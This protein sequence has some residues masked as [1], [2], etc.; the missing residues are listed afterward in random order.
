M[1]K[2]YILLFIGL[3][4]LIKA[5]GQIITSSLQTEL[6]NAGPSD[7]ISIIIQMNDQIDCKDLQDSLLNNLPRKEIRQF[8]VNELKSFADTSQQAIM[9]T[10]TS[11]EALG[12]AENVRQ[13]WIVN[14]ITCKAK[15]AAINQLAQRQDISMLHIDEVFEIGEIV[16]DNVMTPP[17]TAYHIKTMNVPAVWNLGYKG[18]GVVVAVLDT[19]VDIRH[20][21]LENNMWEGDGWNIIAWNDSV[22]DTEGHGTLVAGIIAGDGTAG[23]IT[24]VAPKAKIMAIKVGYDGM[25]GTTFHSFF[26]A[27]IAW[28]LD[29]G[30]DIFNLSWQNRRTI[31]PET[32]RLWRQ[33]MD[34]VL[35]SS[36]VAV[37]AAGNIDPDNP[38]GIPPDRIGVPGRIPPPWKHPHQN[39]WGSEGI[40]SAVVCV[41]AIDSIGNWWQQSEF[42]PVTWSNVPPYN[43][44]PYDAQSEGLRRPDVV[45]PG[46]AITSLKANTIEYAN[47]DGT[48][49]SAPAVAGVMAL[50]LS[51]NPYLMPSELDSI[52]EM[53][54]FHPDNDTTA[55]PQWRM[56]DNFLGAGRIR[57]D[58]AVAAVPECQLIVDNTQ[59][60]N[61]TIFYC[62][63]IVKTGGTLTINQN[64]WFT[65]NRKIIVEPGG[66]LIINKAIISRLNNEVWQ[67]IQVWGDTNVNQFPDQNGNY[68]QG[69][70]IVDDAVIENALSA[71]ELWKPGD[72]TKT[73]GIVFA[74][75]ATF[76]NNAKSVHALCYTNEY[77]GGEAN[78]NSYFKNCTF[79]ITQD[80]PGESEFFKH[81]DLNRVKGIRFEGCDFSLQ[82]TTGVSP[83][84]SAIA[85]YNA[86]FNVSAYCMTSQIP[87][88]QYD[89]CTFT[90][91]RDA[92]SSS[93]NNLYTFNVSR[94]FFSNNLY[95]IKVLG[96]NNFTV[97]SCDF[98]V[99]RYAEDAEC[100]DEGTIANGYGIHATS[101][102]GFAIE[103]NY[104]TKYAHA[105]ASIYVGITIAESQSTNQ[106]YRN[107]FDGLSYGNY[108]VGKNWFEDNT[109][110][111]LAYYCNENTGNWQDFYVDTLTNL[112][113]GIQNP[114]GG[115]YLPAGNTFSPTA[116]WHIHNKG[117]YWIGYFYY[118][119]T[120][121]D[122]NTVFYPNMDKVWKVT[123]VGVYLYENECLSHYGGGGGGG[124]GRG[125]VLTPGE[126]QEAEQDYNNNLAEYNNV[127]SLY[128]YL[129]DGGNTQLILSEVETAFPD[130]MWE[131]RASLLE[132]SPHL[133]TEVL[134][135]TADK[136]DVFPDNVI[137]EIMA[138]NPDELRKGELIQYCAEK[139]NPLP[140][141]M[142]TVLRQV[143]ETGF[144][145]KTILT[146]NMANYNQVKTRVAYDIIRSIL[147]DT[148][149]DVAELRTLLGRLG[150]KR[151]DEQVIAS[152]M[153]EENYSQA[154]SLADA[155]PQTYDYDENELIEHG[156]Y[157]DMLNLMSTLKQQGRTVGEL[158][159]T[160]V[161]SLVY[162]AENTNGTASAQAK[163]ILEYAYGYHFCDCIN[164]DSTGYKSSGSLNPENHEQAYG[165]SLTVSPNPATD[166]VA[167]DY[168]LN[169]DYASASIKITDIT[170]KPVTVIPVSGRLGQ[171]IWNTRKVSPGVYFYNFNA[172]GVN[173]SGKIV[174]N[175]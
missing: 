16:T 59:T 17:D 173:K 69:V 139:E 44:Y 101:S 156:Y 41:G 96:T 90:G 32:L 138:A 48:S 30:A 39:F 165:I 158:D 91:F 22:V 94:A 112:P 33:V 5:Q 71:L 37:V 172:S 132:K 60:L 42:G 151:A 68:P 153:E 4:F 145:Y 81:V 11:L 163:G 155:L 54:A 108:A 52:I 175:N 86:G 58:L 141:Y 105:P 70:L 111:G 146:G 64:L 31:F 51:K 116:A 62:D 147:N 65:R 13:F 45:A 35:E 102:S 125:L 38:S 93:N 168:S 57:A 136:T 26:L 85:A 24:G 78:Y 95:G 72:Y 2:I 109:A 36:C 10:I 104:F 135:A 6:N 129:K 121:G 159:S 171:K 29:H 119:P 107:T 55:Q 133:T 161:S 166:W 127:K 50:M 9:N 84:N 142:L 174:I 100:S 162:I 3:L 128:E 97:I 157:V 82:Q 140:E 118:E 167:F 46:V 154:L 134:K 28:G 19:G 89:R 56:K 25:T 77:M 126:K 113:S 110:K 122:T 74:N 23:T 150:G 117:D 27:G 124:T 49:F 40:Q 115:V 144:T 18:E 15:P 152:Y 83:W 61:D 120:N 169:D 7:M 106:V 103:E 160:E 66:K 87:C 1:K 98:H 170:G 123:R 149:T 8:V 53:T 92:I 63:I 88:N 131:L 79:E 148:V 43:D 67:G 34:C 47:G 130:E 12:Q 143:L 76:R 21:D 99:G 137:F 73:G 14:M 80:Y 164:S 75:D 114:I 20:P